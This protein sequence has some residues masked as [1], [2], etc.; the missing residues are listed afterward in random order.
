[1]AVAISYCTCAHFAFKHDS[2]RA[3]A[4][5]PCQVDGCSCRAFKSH[6]EAVEEAGRQVLGEL[7]LQ[8]M[9]DREEAAGSTDDAPIWRE[10]FY[11]GWPEELAAG[12]TGRS[13]SP[14]FST[15]AAALRWAALYAY[16]LRK[17]FGE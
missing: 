11:I 4:G 5:G 9:R 17:E 12:I 14:T 10:C 8:V 1:M 13:V 16:D 15:R 6:E 2:L 7:D 3:P